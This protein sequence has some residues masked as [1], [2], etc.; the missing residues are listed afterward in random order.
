MAQQYADQFLTGFK[1]ERVLPF[2]G[3]QY[4]MYSAGLKNPQ[5]EPQPA[6]Q[7]VR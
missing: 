4:T 1:T 6:H 2:T 3:M 7:F 5:G